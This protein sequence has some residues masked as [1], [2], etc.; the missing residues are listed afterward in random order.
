ML[1]LTKRIV[2]TKK[3][4]VAIDTRVIS[5][6]SDMSNAAREMAPKS[7]ALPASQRAVLMGCV[8]EVLMPQGSAVSRDDLSRGTPL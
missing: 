8:R 6:C 1:C 5:T 2:P 3:S 7:P 4:D